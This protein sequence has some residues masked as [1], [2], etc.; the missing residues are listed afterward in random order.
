MIALGAVA[1]D[2]WKLAE[3]AVLGV[4]RD[5]LARRRKA[6]PPAGLPYVP[7]WPLRRGAA[8]LPRLAAAE[9]QSERLWSI[10][11]NEA[12]RPRRHP[13]RHPLR[14]RLPDHPGTEGA[15]W[16]AHPL[17][18]LGGVL[19]QAEDELASINQIIGASC[20]GVP[21]LPPPAPACR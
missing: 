21:S 18:K 10:T 19:V 13:A 11:S 15:G 14:R 8:C 9:G 4:V 12:R 2:W 1:P 7:A 5:S 20:A 16:L 6:A 17:A 3:D